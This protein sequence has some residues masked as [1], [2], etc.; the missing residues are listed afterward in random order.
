MIHSTDSE[1]KQDPVGPLGT[2]DFLCPNPGIKPRS[3]TLQAD[4]LPPELSRKL[5]PPN[6][7][8]TLSSVTCTFFNSLAIYMPLLYTSPCAATSV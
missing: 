5:F 4:S 2:K 1:A 6:E 3:P 7:D 8:L